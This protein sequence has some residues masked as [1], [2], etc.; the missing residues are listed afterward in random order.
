MTLSRRNS[1]IIFVM[2]ILCYG[3][4][5]PPLDLI[6]YEGGRSGG[7]LTLLSSDIHQEP[8]YE[9][10]LDFYRQ[11]DADTDNDY[12]YCEYYFEDLKYGSDSATSPI[13]IEVEI[14]ATSFGSL[15]PTLWLLSSGRRPAP[16]WIVSN[17]ITSAGRITFESKD[18]GTDTGW[19]RWNISGAG[20][21]PLFIHVADDEF[22]VSLGFRVGEM[23]GLSIEVSCNITWAF[24]ERYLGLIQIREQVSL[25]NAEI[26]H[27]TAP[28]PLT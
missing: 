16:G 6:V 10:K 22:M 8:D 19:A 28:L 23:E 14:S 1:I 3:F 15:Q 11:D 2:V 13:L 20:G 4:V 7:G 24:I 17:G 18:G 25:P 27:D 26:I 9:I 5:Y 12:Y 21:I